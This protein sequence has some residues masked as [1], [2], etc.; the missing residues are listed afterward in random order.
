MKLRIL[1]AGKLARA[2]VKGLIDQKIAAPQ[3]ICGTSRSE[4]SKKQFLEIHPDLQWNPT[5]SEGLTELSTSDVILLGIKPFQ[6]E[7]LLQNLS[8]KNL[9]P[10]APLYISVLAG[11][12]LEKLQSLIGPE[13]RIIRTMPNTPLMVGK[14]VTGYSLGAQASSKDVETVEKIFSATGKAFAFEEDKLDAVTA[15]SGSG[16]AYFYT[17]IQHLTDAA[18]AA[19]IEE[20][21]A[22]EMATMTAAGASEMLSTTGLP[23]GSLIDQVKSKGGTT[24]AALHSFAQNK[25]SSIIKEAFDSA[26]NRSKELA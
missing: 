22:L 25:F 24:E 11:T 13:A 26:V 12:L 2:I 21:I 7:E 5:P 8:E 15:L 1:G 19:G 3:D 6:A 17:F 10:S 18:A 16:P 9:L 23:A 4:E 20:K 14:G